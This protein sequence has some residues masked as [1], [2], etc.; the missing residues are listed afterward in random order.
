MRFECTYGENGNYNEIRKKMYAGLEELS[1]SIKE[2]LIE[3]CQKNP[4]LKKGGI[5]FEPHGFCVESDYPYSFK[6]VSDIEILEMYFDHGNWAIRSGVVYKD[7]AFINQVNGGDEWA[8]FKFDGEKWHKFESI[9]FK[10]FIESGGFHRFIGKLVSATPEQC[11]KQEYSNPKNITC[12]HC[13]HEFALKGASCDDLGWCTV[14]PECE[15]S[16]D[17]EL[18]HDSEKLQELLGYIRAAEIKA[19]ENGGYYVQ[20]RCNPDTRDTTLYTD[21]DCRKC[22]KEPHVNWRT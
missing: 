16:F 2:A 11:V 20:F 10:T 6:E 13:E 18:P 21:E 7:L 8:T 17:A 5:D 4:W 19:D 3:A 12:L 14:C 22:P 9:T 1:P 15:G